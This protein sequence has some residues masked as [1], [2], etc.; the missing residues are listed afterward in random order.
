MNLLGTFGASLQPCDLAS[1]RHSNL[2][3]A[4]VESPTNLH[5]LD[6]T[7]RVAAETL[8]AETSMTTDDLHA[9]MNLTSCS[10]PSSSTALRAKLN[11]D[12]FGDVLK[13]LK[14]VSRK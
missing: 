5:L 12:M 13:R 4:W 11:K 7:S 14:N 9:D 10:A 2:V 3:G 6:K 8:F 1:M